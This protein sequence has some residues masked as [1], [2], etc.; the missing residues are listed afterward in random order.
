M[1]VLPKSQNRLEYLLYAKFDSKTLYNW[2]KKIFVS[3]QVI[4]K[5]LQY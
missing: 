1:V 5:I 2:T 3:Y 4:E